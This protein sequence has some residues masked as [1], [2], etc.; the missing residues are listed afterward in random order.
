MKEAWQK[1]QKRLNHS[2]KDESIT[3][4]VGASIGIGIAAFFVPQLLLAMIIVSIAQSR[5]QTIDEFLNASNEF[6]LNAAFAFSF[7][8]LSFLILAMFLGRKNLMKKLGLIK[9]KGD[10]IGKTFAVYGI[11]LLFALAA[12]LLI[13][14][15]G[16][17]QEQNTG[18]NDAT[19]ITA[20]GYA[21]FALVIIA[22]LYE[23]ILFRGFMFRGLAKAWKFWPAALFVS[24]LFG[25]AHGQLNVGID[26]FLL[27]IAASYLV[28]ETK[29][30]WPAILLHGIKNTVAFVLLFIAEVN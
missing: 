6:A 17:D 4:G 16:Q 15:L 10:Y 29:S 13:V 11:Y 18:F 14:A 2:Y 7:A 22:P 26:T 27:G 9:P 8:V 21:F 12:S 5:G 30:I 20:L 1:L 3:W 19:E 24:V 25:V 28:W 23:E